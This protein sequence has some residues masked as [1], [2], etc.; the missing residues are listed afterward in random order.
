M[1]PEDLWHGAIGIILACVGL[2]IIGGVAYLLYGPGFSLPIGM[3]VKTSVSG[4]KVFECPDITITAAFKG[5]TVL[6][7][8]SD[9][10]T[11]EVIRTP[12]AT[13][14]NEEGAW[15]RYTKGDESFV[16]WRRDG[17]VLIQENGVVTHSECIL[18]EQ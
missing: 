14:V 10:R 3:R 17:A 11:E 16:F 9:G 12:D 4:A 13:G 8:L 1:K 2:A 15:E 6:L 7:T 5:E 18:Q